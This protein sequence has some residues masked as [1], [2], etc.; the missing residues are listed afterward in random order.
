MC[1]DVIAVN[2]HSFRCPWNF[3]KCIS[4]TSAISVETSS[5]TFNASIIPTFIVEDD[6]TSVPT[7]NSFRLSIIQLLFYETVMKEEVLKNSVIIMVKPRKY[8]KRNDIPKIEVRGKPIEAQ[9]CNITH[10]S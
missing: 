7:H 8:I 3:Y 6:K 4:T 1:I 2:F 10:I 9:K 5:K